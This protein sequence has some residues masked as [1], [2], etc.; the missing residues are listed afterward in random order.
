MKLLVVILLLGF[1]LCAQSPFL[2]KLGDE[3]IFADTTGNVYFDQRFDR[4]TRNYDI[5]GLYV[6]E[7][8]GKMGVVFGPTFLIPCVYDDIRLKK[9]EGSHF[10]F[11]ARKGKFYGLIN[12]KGEILTP[13][14][15]QVIY[16]LNAFGSLRNTNRDY[17]ELKTPTGSIMGSINDKDQFQLEIEEPADEIES[18]SGFFILSKGSKTLLYQ[19]DEKQ[20]KLVKRLSFTDVKLSFFL[21]SFYVTYPK[22]G[23]TE[24]Y[25]YACK[26]L[27]KG[28]TENLLLAPLEENIDA[29][30]GYESVV[31]NEYVNEFKEWELIDRRR[32][33]SRGYTDY[34]VRGFVQVEPA[35]FQLEDQLRHISSVTFASDVSGLKCMV[36]YEYPT[37]IKDKELTFI[38]PGSHIDK[39]PTGYVMHFVYNKKKLVG[40]MDVLGANVI[41]PMKGKIEIIKSDQKNEFIQV[42]T[43]QAS[44]LLYHHLEKN[45]LDTLVVGKPKDSYSISGNVVTITR[46]VSKRYAQIG[47]TTWATSKREYV[48][49]QKN[50]MVS[51]FD[52][53]RSVP[54]IPSWNYAYKDQKVGLIG[55]EARIEVPTAYDSLHLEL[56]YRVDLGP[57]PDYPRQ[58]SYHK[59]QPIVLAFDQD[60]ISIYFPVNGRMITKT[61]PCSTSKPIHVSYD[62]LFLIQELG[63]GFVEVYT[64]EGKK[65]SKEPVRLVSGL[66]TI[67]E[68][69]DNY[70]YLRATD[71]AEKE[72]LIGSNG[73]WFVLP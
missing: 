27:K 72:V 68:F 50:N 44:Y 33:I 23:M 38:V 73:A 62:G 19:H 2:L 39:V 4:V 60:K 57:N 6:V 69:K 9:T 46:P 55:H 37:F 65:L 45:L 17:Y 58:P 34:L 42:E 25:S 61:L 18:E 36:Q 7:Q 14:T 10:S 59:I 15:Y 71:Q 49:I 41:S 43:K 11:A 22:T 56:V 70:W 28:K 52:S 35:N 63:N 64:L 1:N 21:N 3:Y 32:S 53:V 26:L 29:T 16:E 47:K 30:V 20:N 5:Q 31:A 8:E 48:F 24:E 66:S 13:F 67:A 54:A 51:W 40:V 12:A